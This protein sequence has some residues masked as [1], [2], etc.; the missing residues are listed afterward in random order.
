M[1]LLF[2]KLKI[3]SEKASFNDLPFEIKHLILNKLS[4]DDL[5]RIFYNPLL[6]DMIISIL[7]ERMDQFSIEQLVDLY[8]YPELKNAVANQYLSYLASFDLGKIKEILNRETD[9]AII[10]P[11]TTGIAEK[12]LEIIGQDIPVGLTINKQ[13]DTIRA[14]LLTEKFMQLIEEN[15]G[16]FNPFNAYL[17]PLQRT[18][19]SLNIEN[20]NSVH[21]YILNIRYGT[22]SNETLQLSRML[23]NHNE[24]MLDGIVDFTFE[25]IFMKMFSCITN[26]YEFKKM[27]IYTNAVGNHQSG[28]DIEVFSI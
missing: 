2:V 22:Y 28:P 6:I 16:V 10:T 20:S 5:L 12:F 9:L 21:H 7:T 3:M 11:L 25:A 18:M 17:E 13:I 23:H 4:Y 26:N 8:Q 27:T 14:Y 1:N 15:G 24:S 19:V